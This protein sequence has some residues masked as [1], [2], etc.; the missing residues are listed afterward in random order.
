[1]D[2][3]KIP[4]AMWPQYQ[5]KLST[6]LC[7]F[8]N[9]VDA[10]GQLLR[11]SHLCRSS[12]FG[13]VCIKPGHVIIKSPDLNAERMKC[14]NGTRLC[15][16]RIPCLLDPGSIL[17]DF[18]RKWEHRQ[19]DSLSQSPI[20]QDH[21]QVREE[22]AQQVLEVSG[23]QAQEVAARQERDA[24]A[25]QERVPENA[26][27]KACRQAS[28]FMLV[29][30][31]ASSYEGKI[32][33]EY[34]HKLPEN[35]NSKHPRRRNSKHPRRRRTK[36]L[37]VRKAK[38]RMSQ[39]L[40]FESLGQENRML[41]I[42]AGPYV[43][44]ATMTERILAQSVS[45]STLIVVESRMLL[46]R[47]RTSDGERLDV[48]HLKVLFRLASFYAN[49]IHDCEIT[50]LTTVRAPL[51]TKHDDTVRQ[52]LPGAKTFCSASRMV[53]ITSCKIVYSYASQKPDED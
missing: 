17:N 37:S 6:D 22:A 19:E 1:M 34:S 49:D 44:V 43:Q 2:E 48:V 42:I 53:A 13:S 38:R 51:P 32:R 14:H 15:K 46:V 7:Q 47:R 33:S 39:E 8:D 16:C 28:E 10:G 35:P 20:T 45:R 18:A 31:H 25:Q 26:H 9:P 27:D 41:V 29:D 12:N 5:S 30:R 3:V 23:Q 4:I 24:A 50:C 36:L 21:K 11:C 52:G 40:S